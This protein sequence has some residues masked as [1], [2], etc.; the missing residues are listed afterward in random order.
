MGMAGAAPMDK[1][2][3]RFGITIHAIERYRERA[4]EWLR[5]RGHLDDVA[6]GNSLDTRIAEAWDAGKVQDVLDRGEPAR[7]VDLESSELGRLYAVVVINNRHDGINRWTVPTVLTGEMADASW[8]QGRWVE[9]PKEA[10]A[11]R[12]TVA[13]KT[14]EPKAFMLVWTDDAGFRQREELATRDEVKDAVTRL[15]ASGG[16]DFRVFVEIPLTVRI[17]VSF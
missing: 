1:Y 8:A 9:A 14:P 5:E 4:G 2:R 10:V 7:V 15:A 6:V 13:P 11:P 12:P 16:K 3:R 17:E